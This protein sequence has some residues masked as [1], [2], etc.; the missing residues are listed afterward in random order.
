VI[1]LPPVTRYVDRGGVHIAYQV[2]GDGPFDLVFVPGFVGHLDLFWEEGSESRQFLGRLAS[3]S[4]LILFDKRGT[5]LSDRDVGQ[6]SLEE[7]IDDVLAVMEAAG[8]QQAAVAGYSEGGLMS[9]LFAATHPT[10]V[11]SLVLMCTTARPTRAPDYG[12]GAETE[13]IVE[14]IERIARQEWGQGA[15]I[16]IFAPSLAENPRVRQ[17]IGRF[18]RLAAGP[19]Y[20]LKLVELLR[21]ADLRGVLP[22]LQVP[23]LVISRPGDLAMGPCH[24][25]YLAEH[26]RGAR[27]IEFPG[28]HL[29]WLE[30]DAILGEIEEFLT[31]SRARK[32]FDRALATVLFTDIVAS[33]EHAGNLGDQ[34]WRTLLDRHDEIA[35]ANVERHR[36]R[37]IKA[38]GDGVLATFDGPARGIRCACSLR[39]DVSGLGIELRA[40]LHTGEVELRGDDVGGLA[41]HI[42]ARVEAAAQPG[43][44]LVSRTVKDLVAGSGL[45]FADRG[46]HALKGVPEEWRLYAVAGDG[47]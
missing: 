15:T 34:R 25:H 1:D 37:L 31:G 11:S 14:R 22:T 20:V 6:P 24:G 33:T 26:I 42:A 21:H 19:A 18:E 17:A 47:P 35:R 45:T 12:C 40:G 30:G 46:A 5:G 39:E 9:I 8:S 16:D 32:Y 4:R 10:R 36:G 38:T 3:F 23:T 7:R 13:A 2:V 44:V 28:D 27:Y 41:V 43:E 29:P